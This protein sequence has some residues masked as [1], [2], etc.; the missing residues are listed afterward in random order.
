MTVRITVTLPDD[1]HAALVKIGDSSHVSASAVVR[2][3]LSDVLPRMTSV[4]EF[5]GSGEPMT[6]ET[7]ERLDVWS[8][9]L[10]TVLHDAPDMFEA[11]RT[12]IDEPPTGEV[13]P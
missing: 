11:F 1:L 9:D 5:L 10:R 2:S 13:K 4:L 8:R 3:I 7:A 6:A 12:V